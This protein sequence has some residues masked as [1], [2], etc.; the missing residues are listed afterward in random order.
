MRCAVAIDIIA[1]KDRFWRLLDPI[2]AAFVG[3]MV[4]HGVGLSDGT[5]FKICL[6]AG[7][8]KPKPENDASC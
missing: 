8:I 2:A 6:S 3:F 1:S 4:A 7:R 5:L